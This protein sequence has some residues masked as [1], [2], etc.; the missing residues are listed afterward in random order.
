MDYY[1]KAGP[2]QNNKELSLRQQLQEQMTIIE[3][4]QR[5]QAEAMANLG[6]NGVMGT[7]TLEEVK[8][9]EIE[10]EEVDIFERKQ[11]FEELTKRMEKHR[12][13]YAHLR[14]NDLRFN[15]YM[16]KLNKLTRLDLGLDLESYKD[17]INNLKQFAHVN[18]DFDIFAKDSLALSNPEL[19]ELIE[20]RFNNSG[21]EGEGFMPAEDLA[22]FNVRCQDIYNTLRKLRRNAAGFL[23]SRDKELM[24]DFKKHLKNYMRNVDVYE[25][26]KG[27]YDRKQ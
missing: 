25:Q 18:H 10:S 20:I 4:R 16:K 9:E 22:L 27:L 13:E 3:R 23:T 2:K 11:K 5:L 21:K 12:K 24:E 15:V 7:P 1:R 17:Y 26:T 6:E 19:R 8:T 14:G